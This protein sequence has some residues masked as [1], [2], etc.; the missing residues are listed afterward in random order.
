MV[1]V[2][3]NGTIAQEVTLL[4]KD[5]HQIDS[6]YPLQVAG[7][8][9]TGGLTDTQLRAAAVPVKGVDL[10]VAT[11]I[12]GQITV[13]TAG[14]EVQGSNVA[15]SDGVFVK[16][17]GTNTGKVYVGNAGDGTISS[18]TG[19]ELAAGECILIQVDNLNKLWFDSAVNVEKF[20][21]MKA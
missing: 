8:V 7:P 20:C 6:S 5:G 12:S 2:N 19:Y 16:A 11:A 15:L 17:M 13:T 10:S 4:D 14:T 3:A 9:V 21:W 1:D 18:T